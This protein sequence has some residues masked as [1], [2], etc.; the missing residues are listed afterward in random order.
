MMRWVNGV[1]LAAA[2]AVMIAFALGFY[3]FATSVQ[4]ARAPIPLPEA[5]AIVSLTG[6]SKERLETGMRLLTEGRGRRLLISGVNPR[7]TDQDV[8][9]LLGG[10]DD[11]IECCV[12]LGRQAED[13]LGNASETAA[14]AA[15]KGFTRIIVVTDDYHLP[16]SL[17]ELQL[18]MPNARLIGY[19]VK[20]RLARARVWTSDLAAAGRLAGEYVKYL[21]I[22][23]RVGLLDPPEKPAEA[24]DA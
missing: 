8:Y 23:S 7:I 6:G 3:S 13:T 12:D 16:R 19:P 17:V 15:E 11:L 14:W 9:A 1:V 18:A 4:Q 24:E 21:A 20:T 22:R 10:S 5:D 2:T